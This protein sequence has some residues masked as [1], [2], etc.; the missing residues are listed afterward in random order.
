MTPLH[1]KYLIQNRWARKLIA[2]IDFLLK[3]FVLHRRNFA[4]VHRPE[5][6]LLSNIAFMGDAVIATTVLRALKKKFPDAKIGFLVSS[7]S[8]EV[9]K[10]HPLIDWVHVF[11]HWYVK[12]SFGSLRRHWETQRKVVKGIDA[13]GYDLAI[14]LHPY[15]PNSISLL[16]RT[17]IP[18]RIGYESAG[19]G[20]LLTH[21]LPFHGSGSYIGKSFL[22][23]LQGLG[24]RPEF[25]TPLPHYFLQEEKKRMEGSY[26]PNCI[27]YTVIHM[28]TSSLLKEWPLESWIE[29]VKKLSSK[30]H[31]LVFTGQ[32]RRE[33]DL[34]KVACSHATNGIDLANRLRWVE[35]VQVIQQAQLLISVDSA[36]IHIAAAAM[37]PTI[38]IFCGISAM[39]MWLPPHEKCKGLI[40]QVPC[41]PCF[42]KFGC[43]SMNCIRKLAPDKVMEAVERLQ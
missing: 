22:Q 14:E 18:I 5:K 11:D 41:S 37:V 13:I 25:E 21:P 23:L 2:L 27:G 34:T 43:P 32:G 38:A 7:K 16:Y 19:L 9:M 24:I 8:E 17:K 29:L 42:N 10:C 30:G 35:F 1:G 28:G 15:F 6:I 33:T 4:I 20:P 36:S 39:E 40:H 26:I 12:R 3:F 31:R